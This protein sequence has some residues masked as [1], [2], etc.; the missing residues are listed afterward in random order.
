MTRPCKLCGAE[1]CQRNQAAR[2][3]QATRE[4]NQTPE[5]LRS[6]WYQQAV[7]ACRRRMVER[8]TNTKR[9]VSQ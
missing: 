1:H 5:Y 9:G 4:Q 6:E 8:A 2:H 7:D 3:W